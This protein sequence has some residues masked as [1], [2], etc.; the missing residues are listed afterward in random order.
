MN[1]VYKIEYYNMLELRSDLVYN[2]FNSFLGLGYIISVL[3]KSII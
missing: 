1:S 3:K 2:K